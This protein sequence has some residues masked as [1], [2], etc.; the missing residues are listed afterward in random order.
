MFTLIKKVKNILNDYQYT[1]PLT[2]NE[3]IVL[4]KMMSS[5]K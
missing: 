4:I 1:I 3:E 2:M 5:Y